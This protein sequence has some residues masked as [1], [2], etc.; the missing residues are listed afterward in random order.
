MLKITFG[1]I[2]MS[3]K[4]ILCALIILL[5]F[6]VTG[7]GADIS[8]AWTATFDTQVGQQSYTYEFSQ[9]GSELTGSMKSGNGDAK[10]ENGKVEGD[11]V[12]FVENMNYQGMA[13]KIDYTGKIVSDEEISFTRKVGDFGTEQLTAKRVK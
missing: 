1:E 13:L 7:Y 11:T 6:P 9:K 8:G 10:V 2:I 4:N 3:Y 5:N 12:T